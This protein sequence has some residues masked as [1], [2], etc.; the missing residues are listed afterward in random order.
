MS[1]VLIHCFFITRCQLKLRRQ[2]AGGVYPNS[3]VNGLGFSLADKPVPSHCEM[4]K[5]R[6]YNLFHRQMDWVQWRQ[7]LPYAIALSSDT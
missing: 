5:Q 4:S 6:C 1:V 2:N 3:T 7:P